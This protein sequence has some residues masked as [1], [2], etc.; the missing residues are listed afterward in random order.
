VEQA[1]LGQTDAAIPLLGLGTSFY[2]GGPE[3]LRHGT[4]LA[5]LADRLIG[6]LAVLPA[7]LDAATATARSESASSHS[8][9]HCVSMYREVIEATLT[10]SHRSS[11][12]CCRPHFLNVLSTPF[13][14]LGI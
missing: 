3:P 9:E 2:S 4:Q 5:A 12:V 7:E 8:A 11:Y 6:P 13:I 14:C 1:R 10:R